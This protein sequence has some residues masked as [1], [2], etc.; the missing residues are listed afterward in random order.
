MFVAKE[1]EQVCCI[2]FQTKKGYIFEGENVF[3]FDT[4]NIDVKIIKHET[5]SGLYDDI[6]LLRVEKKQIFKRVSEK[7]FFMT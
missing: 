5:F 1:D 3:S 2:L 4:V 6:L 7:T